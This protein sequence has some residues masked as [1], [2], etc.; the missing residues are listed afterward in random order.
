MSGWAPKDKQPWAQGEPYT[1]YNR[2][3]LQLRARLMPYLYSITF[4]AHRTGVPPVRAMNLEFPD[5]QWEGANDSL[6]YQFMSGPS[7]LVAPV[8]RDESLRDGIALPAGEWVD[9][10]D[11]ARHVG[12]KILDAYPA[13]LDKLPVFVRAG[14]IIPMWP[15]MLFFR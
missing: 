11:G 2:R 7:F 4:E 15:P 8:F 10:A 1:T 6:A 9:Y 14:S 12:P 5:E 13:P 3:A